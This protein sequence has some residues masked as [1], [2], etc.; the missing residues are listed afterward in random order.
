[1]GLGTN[2]VDV[3]GKVSDV[4]T[5]GTNCH[6]IVSIGW[7]RCLFTCT[8]TTCVVLAWVTFA[9]PVARDW[10]KDLALLDL[11][12]VVLADM[13]GETFAIFVDLEL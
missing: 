3:N 12:V 1:M 13:L 11:L 8:L 10:V 9:A 6:V 2:V 5:C 4:D 7:L